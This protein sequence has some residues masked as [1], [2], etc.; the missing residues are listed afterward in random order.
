MKLQYT[1]NL[2]PY[3]SWKYIHILKHFLKPLKRLFHI[4][5]HSA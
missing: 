1:S 3:N 4:T 5:Q 2:H